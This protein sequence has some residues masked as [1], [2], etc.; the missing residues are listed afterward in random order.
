MADKEPHPHFIPGFKVDKEGDWQDQTDLV[1][2]IFGQMEQMGYEIGRLLFSGYAA[3]SVVDNN[4]QRR[5]FAVTSVDWERSIEFN[6]STGSPLF[7]ADARASDDEQTT[8]SIGV[9][10]TELLKPAEDIDTYES[11]ALDDSIQLAEIAIF[12]VSDWRNDW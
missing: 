10:N 8:P 5:I 11:K 6:H 3:G 2:M 4:L 7:Y 1:T 12:D 9:Y